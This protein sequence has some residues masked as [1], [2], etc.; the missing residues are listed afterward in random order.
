VDE[1]ACGGCEAR[2]R[3]GHVYQL[4]PAASGFQAW[5]N[6][7]TLGYGYDLIVLNDPAEAD[8]LT[9]WT[10]T[11]QID[12]GLND[13]RVDGTFVWADGRP[14]DLHLWRTSGT[15]E[16]NGGTNEN[17]VFTASGFWFDNGCA[18]SGRYVC[19][20]VA[21]T[22]AP[23]VGTTETCNGRDD[24]R[25]G[26]I[27]EDVCDCPTRA[28][29]HHVYQ[30]CTTGRHWDQARTD[31]EDAGGYTMAVIDSLGEAQ[32]VGNIMNGWI[33]LND[34]AMESHF[35]YESATTVPISTGNAAQG[36]HFVFWN[37]GEPNDAGGMPHSENCVT[38][39]GD[40][41]WNDTSCNDTNTY[42]CE[43]AIVP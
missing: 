30:V 24:D 19:E 8:F 10:G 15:P 25:D 39:G 31:C 11:E 42:T 5:G 40:G 7:T 17:C 2:E 34:I 43:R 41:R 29:D 21:L 23:P 32:A 27:D 4:C 16:P 18:S 3:A 38:G 13:F 6:C 33:G 14:D 1:T 22:T 37:T 35:V 36:G 12:I 28:F 9:T 20:G 26:P